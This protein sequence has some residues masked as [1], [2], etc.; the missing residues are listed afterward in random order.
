MFNIYA[1]M[2]TIRI[3]ISHNNIYIYVGTH[4]VNLLKLTLF[5]VKF[6]IVKA[7][8]KRSTSGFTWVI[9]DAQTTNSRILLERKKGCSRSIYYIVFSPL[10]I[11]EISCQYYA[12]K[13]V[14]HPSLSMYHHGSGGQSGVV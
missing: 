6:I 3:D 8:R 9:N 1:M 5:T 4:T 12:V 14:K 13:Y 7:M 11:D 10:I 2:Y